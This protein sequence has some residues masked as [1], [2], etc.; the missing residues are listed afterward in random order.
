MSRPSVLDV[1]T[2]GYGPLFDRLRAVADADDR[3]RA[4]WLSG[5]LARG[6]ADAASDLDV[7]IAVRDEDHA[8]FTGAWRE[9]LAG[10]A[11]TVVARALPSPPG[12][13]YSVTATCERLDVVV[14]AVS[15]VP[16]SPFR[17][18]LAVFDRDGLD[19]RV[20][21]AAPEA[22][23]DPARLASLV[24]ECFRQQ[25]N[26]PTVTVREDWL[27]GVVAVQQIHLILYQLL[28]AANAPQP[29]M[30][31][32][33]WSAR[34]TAAQRRVLEALP[35]PQPARESVL[36]ARDAAAEAFVRE[37]RAVLA[38]NGVPW[39]AELE[40]AVAVHLAREV[41][42]LP[43][44]PGWRID[45][46][47]LRDVPDDP[48]AVDVSIAALRA[49]LAAPGLAPADELELRARL[50]GE[51]RLAGRLDLAVEVLDAALALAERHGTPRQR[52]LARVRLAHARQWRREWA[53]SDALFAR[54][55]ADVES[56]PD[57]DDRARA[58]VLQHAGKNHFDQGRWP[59]A[60]EL[61]ARALALR[62]AAG[63]EALAESS[64]QAVDTARGRLT[65]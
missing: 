56:A 28:V 62:Q 15:A 22:G 63:D 49:R 7:L 10:I 27:M 34:L 21:A 11:P 2:P 32:K 65:G 23:P 19:A 18:R 55:L 58:F 29:P 59:E 42:V 4:M 8:A 39:P 3:I 45:P 54:C 44:P 40:L 53:E 16:A 61:F 35:V 24:E 46:E 13:F 48:A 26:L 30:G 37:A 25:V 1:L 5:S 57:L 20:P 36:A 60:A 31:V 12:S 33:Q 64:R 52:L 47:T 51:A 14:E 6:H 17:H 43:P 9:W 41:G 50:G 38:A